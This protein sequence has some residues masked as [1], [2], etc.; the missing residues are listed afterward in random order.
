VV[1]TDPEPIGVGWRAELQLTSG[2]RLDAVAFGSAAFA[3]RQLDVGETVEFDGRIRTMGDR[4]WLEAR[5]IVGRLTIDAVHDVEPGSR[6]A[7]LVNAVRSTVADGGTS[8][9][10]R[11]QALYMGLVVGDDRFQHLSQQAQFRASGLT[12]L[13]AVSGQNVAFVLLVVRPLLLLLGHRARLVATIGVLALFVAVTRAEPSVLRATACAAAATWATM[14]GRQRSGVRVLATGVSV[15]VLIDPFLVRVV[16]FQLSVAA[17]AGILALGPAIKRRLPFPGSLGDPI[18]VTTAAQL[19]VSPLL[20]FYFGPIPLASLPANVAAGWSAGVVMT[21]GLT[22]GSLAGL[23]HQAGWESAAGVVQWPTGW[24]LWWIDE[25]A[26]RTAAAPIPRLGSTQLLALCAAGAMVAV[27]HRQ[28]RLWGR[29]ATGLVVL[30]VTGVVVGAMPSAPVRPVELAPGALLLPATPAGPSVLILSTD[31]SEQV[32][33][34]AIEHNIGRIDVVVSE[35]GD[36][37]RARLVT[38]LIEVTDVELVLAPPLHRIRG[39][40]RLEQEQVIITGWGDVVVAPGSSSKRL[41][42]GLP[43]VELSADEPLT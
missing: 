25:V 36:A 38:A 2:E 10:H 35:R 21:L 1:R 23:L 18:S 33:E 7:R 39:A 17:S 28:R 9:G 15:L 29:A 19:G 3:L 42:I 37:Q 34:S 12:H 43:P 41:D 24:M 8:F 40:T 27:R 32:V 4:P 13:L 16:G 26:R 22:V 20:L 31:A 5:H 11:R 6:V 14:D 30:I